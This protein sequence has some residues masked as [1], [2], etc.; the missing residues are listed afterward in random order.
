LK[1]ELEHIDSQSEDDETPQTAEERRH[2]E[3]MEADGFTLVQ[4]GQQ[5]LNRVKTRD[6][7]MGTT[8]IGI[9]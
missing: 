2:R 8:I 4:P 5:N 7:P 3:A 1:R 6:D 9:S